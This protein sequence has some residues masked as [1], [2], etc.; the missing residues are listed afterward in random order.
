MVALETSE[1]SV[2]GEEIEA[3]SGGFGDL[4]SRPAH[5]LRVETLLSC[6]E[7]CNGSTPLLETLPY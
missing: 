6:G 7:V 5:R 4:G 3:L 1:G 2:T